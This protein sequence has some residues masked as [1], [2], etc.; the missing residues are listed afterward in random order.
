MQLYFIYLT[1]LLTIQST[2]CSAQ[3]KN[4]PSKQ[5]QW[6]NNLL[7]AMS[8]EEKIGQ[9]FMIQAYSNQD[10]THAQKISLFIKKYHVGGL[11]FFQGSPVRQAILTNRFQK[12][13]TKIPLFIAMDL[14]WGLGMRLDSAIS[15]PRQMTLGA[16][17]DNSYIYQMGAEVA[18]QCKRIGVNINFAPVAD[19][20]SNPIN[21]VIGTRSFGEDK[22]KVAQKA[23]AYMKGMQ[24][25]GLIATAKHFPGHGDTDRDSHLSLPI[26]RHGRKRIESEELYPFSRLVEEGI[27][28]M[29]IAHLH[30]PAYDDRKNIPASLSKEIVS[31]IA[32]EKLNFQGLIFTDALR[33]KGVAKYHAAGQAALQALM[34][35]ND[36]LLMP[37]DLPKAFAAIKQAVV[38]GKLSETY[39]EKKVKKILVNKYKTGLNNLKPIAV[40]G[41]YEDLNHPKA[42]ALKEI[43][44]EQAVT[45][46]KNTDNRLP[47]VDTYHSTFAAVGIGAKKNNHFHKYLSLYAPF[48]K[49]QIPSASSPSTYQ[50]ILNKLKNK[51][52]VIVSLHGLN[53]NGKKQYGIS[54]ESLRFIENLQKF[55]QVIII[56]FG[57]PY[58]LK[59]FENTDELLCAYTDD[60][61]MQRAVP[62]ILFGA[63]T[64]Q[65][66]LPV[67]VSAYIPQ[68]TGKNIPDLG[69]LSF[70]LPERVGMDTKKLKKIDAIALKAIAQEATPGC[71]ILVAKN[72]K[73]VLSQSYGYHT[74]QKKIAVKN[75]DLYDIASLTK[76]VASLQAIMSLEERGL[77]NLDKKIGDYL[78]ETNASDKRNILLKDI[79]THQAGFVPFIPHAAS[80]INSKKQYDTRFLSQTQTDIFSVPVSRNLYAIYNIQDSLWHWTLKSKIDTSK[81]NNGYV[82]YKYSDIGFYVFKRIIEKITEDSLH[83]YINRNL[84]QPLG[85][86]TMTYLPIQKFNKQRIIPTELDT[87]FR[88]SL[89]HGYVHDSGAALSGGVGGHAG[90]FSNA[91]D[92][93]IVMQ[94]NLQKGYYGGQRYLQNSTLPKFNRQIYK[95]N[96]NRRGLGWDKPALKSKG[97]T[98]KYCSNQ[99]FG[100]TGF[101]GTCVWVDP[102][103]K[104]VYVFLSNRVYPYIRNYKL[105]H[106]NVRT[107]IHDAIYQAIKQ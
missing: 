40:E 92:I 29:M 23:I 17:K 44:C 24:D 69:R 81:N 50:K 39:I 27:Q 85:L 107:N 6:A 62:Q 74:Y 60:D 91:L 61:A 46:V 36:I 98:S 42:Q 66:R 71:Q 48:V 31:G 9:L 34:A 86:Q 96:N 16:I 102:K 25:H 90:V 5:R 70:G 101:T 55:S 15:F 106:Y 79:L 100:H 105:L 45:V 32:F 95:N 93:A 10:E 87:Y 33:M 68:G 80:M 54:N 82:K 57:N 77:I 83:R 75:N 18:R 7:S 67:S 53:D 4:L 35:G 2:T 3:N 13:S 37:E 20:N 94:M 103:Y 73:V 58:S 41:M 43:L 89:V 47:F 72:G 14:E 51:E 38:N 52:Y 22:N 59:Y 28:G 84:Y 8:L 65:A 11:I 97:N 30:I 88:K 63:I 64:N 78:P 21:P 26:I 76:V 1:I 19:I 104:L 49:Y 56:V 99:T 12:L